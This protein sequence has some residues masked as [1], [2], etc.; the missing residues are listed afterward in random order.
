[1]QQLKLSDVFLL[2]TKR[3]PTVREHQTNPSLELGSIVF[4]YHMW[5]KDGDITHRAPLK[6]TIFIPHEFLESVQNKAG[7]IRDHLQQTIDITLADI[8]SENPDEWA[9]SMRRAFGLL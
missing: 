1:M 3:S 7:A 4:D 2:W 8:N 9:L 5:P 6:G